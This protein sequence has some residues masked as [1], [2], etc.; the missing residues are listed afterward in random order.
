[1]RRHLRLALL[2][3]VLMLGG[4]VSVF[5]PHTSAQQP[6]LV[7]L[8]QGWN[9]VAWTGT[10][11]PASGALASLGDAVSAVYGYNSDSQSFARYVFG[12]AEVST[13]TDFEPERAYWVLAL[14]ATDW[15]VQGSVG[16]SCPAT[17][18]CPAA[19]P[20]PYCPSG[21]DS[22]RSDSCAA[23]ALEIEYL[24][25]EMDIAETVGVIG[26]TPSEIQARLDQGTQ[27]FQQGCQGI[28]LAPP[29]YLTARCAEVGR[30][31]GMEQREVL[32][33]PDPQYL[34]WASQFDSMVDKYC[35]P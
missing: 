27:A 8:A 11:Q 16:P 6:R 22:F 14:R 7:H 17:T 24:G 5:L 32:H 29:S 9:L 4:A 34:V 10:N 21:L 12:R 20:C 19:T 31:K 28:G 3:A 26:T 30:W 23:I 35:T 25:V 1:M 33:D 15:S 2:V 13:L 18:P